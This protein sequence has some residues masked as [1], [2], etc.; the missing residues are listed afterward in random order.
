MRQ[1]VTLLIALAAIAAVGVGYWRRMHDIRVEPDVIIGEGGWLFPGWDRL[2][3][4]HRREA[5]AGVRLV[6]QVDAQL[7]GRGVGLV[8]LLIPNKS[9]N[10][11]EHLPAPR[12]AQVRGSQAYQALVERLRHEGVRVVDAG[13]TLVALK[14]SGEPAYFTRDAHWTGAAAEAVA[15]PLASAVVAL[16]PIPGTAGDGE[17][18]APWRTWRRYPDLVAIQRRQGV[19]TYGEEDFRL[20]DYAVPPPPPAPV[21]IVGSSFA[22]R[23]YG[24]PQKLSSLLDRRVNIFIRFGADGC[25]QAMA[26]TLQASQPAPPKVIVWQLSEGSFSS[27]AAQA[28]MSAHFKSTH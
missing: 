2:V 13:P 27:A 1:F 7:K 3:D 11:P 18:I 28:A 12:R 8:V 23:Q 20:R 9:R 17:K 15:A 5:D 14:A 6:R 10:V 16:G 19:L 24:L 4:D 25:W 21:L 26:E 22:D